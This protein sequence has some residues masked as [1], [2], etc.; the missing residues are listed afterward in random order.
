[1][2]VRHSSRP[3]RLLGLLLTCLLLSACASQSVRAP[4]PAAV[5]LAPAH[6]NLHA[7]L[8]MQASAEYQANMRGGFAQARRQLDLALASPDWDALPPTERAIGSGFESLPPAIIVDVDE[9]MLDN[10]AFQARGVRDDI[11]FSSE[12][13]QAWSNERRALALPGALEFAGYAASRG[14]TVYYVT[15]RNHAAEQSA[16]ADN[17]LALGFPLLADHSNLLLKGDPRASA[18]PK[19]A[20]RAWVGARHRVLLMLGDQLGDF[21][22]P[23]SDPAGRQQAMTANLGW[24]GERWFMLPNP[25]YGDWERA[26]STGCSPEEVAA[27]RRACVRRNLR[28][29]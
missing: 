21:V 5:T 6:D 24:W 8:W 20:R 12:R 25:T 29:D 28:T 11:D 2:I 22:D 16:T 10:S 26:L 14:V 1:M 9:T 23:P 7:T 18:V 13:W 17:L 27:D 19:S 4:E 15:N 3:S